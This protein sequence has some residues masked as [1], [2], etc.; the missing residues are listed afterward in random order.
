M[1]GIHG[2]VAQLGEVSEKHRYA[3][4]IAAGNRLGQ[5]VVDNDHIAAKAIEIL[6]KKKA[7]RLTFL[8]LN[9]IRSQNKNYAISRFENNKEP[10]FIDKAI[11]LIS[12]NEVYA[13]VFKY[14][15]GDTLV[16][17][18][19]VSARLSKQKIRLVTLGGELLEASGAITGGSKLNKD[20]AYRFGINNDLDDS[21]PIKERLMVIKEAL[22]E[23]NNDL[24]LKNNRINQLNS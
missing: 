24:I 20:L 23:S 13:D 10:G 8:P 17:T 14:V 12:F 11:N 19:L 2:Y 18:D 22:K 3:L 15:F 6:K 21:T 7:G 16:F 5:I 1:E 4:E 9:R